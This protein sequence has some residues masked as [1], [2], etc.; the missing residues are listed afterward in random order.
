MEYVKNIRVTSENDR[1]TIH[2]G[3]IK[4]D[5][6]DNREQSYRDI[7]K[8]IETAKN[9]VFKDSTFDYELGGKHKISKWGIY[10][11]HIYPTFMYMLNCTT[12]NHAQICSTWLT[13]YCEYDKY[14]DV[15][16]EVF[17]DYKK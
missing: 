15:F 6:N 2:F 8:C 12:I 7:E 10:N 16:E 14:H 4:Y 9:K 17:N 3:S 13:I 11:Y 1:C 5:D